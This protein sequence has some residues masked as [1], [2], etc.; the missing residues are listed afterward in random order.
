MVGEKRSE[1]ARSSATRA[2]RLPRGVLFAAAAIAIV[3]VSVTTLA[4][5][6][7][8]APEPGAANRTTG[9]LPSAGN[10]NTEGSTSRPETGADGASPQSPRSS[11]DSLGAAP[12]AP[13]DPAADGSEL[14]T[15]SAPP[16]RT[17][18]AV[19]IPEG[20]TTGEFEIR[21]EPYGFAPSAGEQRRVVVRIESSTPSDDGG[22]RL[23]KD[24]AGV[25]AL[26]EYAPTQVPLMRLGGTY[27]GRMRVVERQGAG[28]LVLLTATPV[29]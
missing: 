29:R 9:G 28:T 14:A 3:V 22:V 13:R 12:G 25:N 20:F 8:T 18:A 7:R 1:D 17:L 27:Q 26:V 16:A 6:G 4:I 21:F 2:V 19:S 24:F 5:L 10:Q 15:L 11:A 23:A